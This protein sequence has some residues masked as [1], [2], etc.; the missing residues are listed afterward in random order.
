MKT[1]LFKYRPIKFLNFY[2]SESRQ[3][4]TCYGEVS[5]EQF[6]AFEMLHFGEID[7]DDFTSVAFALPKRIAKKCSG[8]LKYSMLECFEF[9]KNKEELIAFLSAR[10]LTSRLDLIDLKSPL[11]IMVERDLAEKEI[12]E[13]FK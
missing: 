13:I 8:F 2:L 9:L 7:D 11:D 3:Y 6:K 12:M 1:I 4:P 5:E 10:Q